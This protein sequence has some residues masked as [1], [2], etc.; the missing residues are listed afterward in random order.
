[1]AID[2]SHLIPDPKAILAKK[3]RNKKRKPLESAIQYGEALTLAHFG[4][5]GM[6]WG[7]R[8]SEKE[9][10]GG[11]S[12]H[13]ESEDHRNAAAA[14]DKARKHGTKSLSNKE[15]QDM[16]NRMNLEQQY[17]RV[18]PTPKGVRFLKAGAKFTGD[19]LINVGKQQATKLAADHATK[20][21]GVMLKR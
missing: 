15:L 14:K 3:S 1:M 7:V 11:K 9:L 21:V 17:A 12:S 8:R 19:V 6:R 16:I 5:K 4:V 10:H 2:T 13:P 20:L 18:A